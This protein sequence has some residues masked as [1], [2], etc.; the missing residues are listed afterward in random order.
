MKSIEQIELEKE[1]LKDDIKIVNG[2]QYACLSCALYIGASTIS[3]YDSKF[4][5]ALTGIFYLYSLKYSNIKNKLEKQLIILSK[6][7]SEINKSIKIKT[8][9]K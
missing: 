2:I 6:E 9:N 5:I 4:L 7:E 3:N 8:K 1:I